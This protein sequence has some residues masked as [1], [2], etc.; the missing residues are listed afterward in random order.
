M[1][2]ALQ[3]LQ[4]SS[5]FHCSGFEPYFAPDRLDTNVFCRKKNVD[6]LH[7][8]KHFLSLRDSFIWYNIL[9]CFTV[10]MWVWWSN[11]MYSLQIIWELK[12]QFW[13]SVDT[14]TESVM[15]QTLNNSNLVSAL[16]VKRKSHLHSRSNNSKVFFFCVSSS[17]RFLFSSLYLPL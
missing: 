5:I 2:V 14:L 7:Y 12:L 11:L 13:D 17:M 9:Y 10:M 8:L 3:N 1:Q 16:K 6:I 4:S 15:N